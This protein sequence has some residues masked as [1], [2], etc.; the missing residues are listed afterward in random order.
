MKFEKLEINGL[1]L[2]KPKIIEDDRGFFSETYRKDLLENFIFDKLNFC[3]QNTSESH[4]GVLRGLHF[5]IYPKAQ[6][7]LISVLSG[8]ILD[9][10]VDIRENS[11]TYGKYNSIILSDTNNYQLLIPKGFA[12]GFITLSKIARINYQVDNY[13]SHKN[14]KGINPFDPKLGINWIIKKEKILLND[15]DKMYP[16]IENSSVY[17]F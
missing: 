7:K 3:Q 9:V 12:H 17:R 2:C 8:E 11:P 5:Q 6:T 1:V 10:A 14:E 16:N 13:Y 4:Y 15:K